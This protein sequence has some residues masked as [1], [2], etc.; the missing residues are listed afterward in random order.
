MTETGN[1]EGDGHPRYG[2]IT[3]SIVDGTGEKSCELDNWIGLDDRRPK[4][5]SMT[6]H[7]PD[8][9]EEDDDDLETDLLPPGAFSDIEWDNEKV[10]EATG[11]EGASMERW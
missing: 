9:D 2:G 10:E 4:L 1:A 8:S 6:I 3:W 11:N 7:V 5:G